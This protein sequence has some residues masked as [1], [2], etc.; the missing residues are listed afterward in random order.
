MNMINECSK[1]PNP[2]LCWGICKACAHIHDTAF[3]DVVHND[4][5]SWMYLL[6]ILCFEIP[7][8]YCVLCPTRFIEN[9]FLV[10][11]KTDNI[12]VICA[13]KPNSWLYPCPLEGRRTSVQCVAVTLHWAKNRSFFAPRH[14]I[15]RKFNFGPDQSGIKNET[16]GEFFVRLMRSFVFS[17]VLL[18]SPRVAS[19]CTFTS[20]HVWIT[21][22]RL[23]Y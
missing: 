22:I 13:K 4:P 20:M 19:Y 1:K 11:H 7:P 16:P 9:S 23:G 8:Y 21:T 6:T 17:S 3:A 14:K 5:P 12:P 2:G 15:Y 10:Q 18:I